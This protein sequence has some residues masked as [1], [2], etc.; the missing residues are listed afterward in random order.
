MIKNENKLLF[1]MLK[2]A[3]PS[4][5]DATRRITLTME[6]GSCPTCECEFLI[7]SVGRIETQTAK[8]N[9][10]PIDQSMGSGPPPSVMKI[11]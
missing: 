5:P 6:V 7:E 3:I 8:F 4:I 10:V 2:Q 1:E 11:G 9:L